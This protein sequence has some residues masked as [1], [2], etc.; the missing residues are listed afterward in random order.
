MT[1]IYEAVFECFESSF[2]YKSVPKRYISQL[3]QLFQQNSLQFSE[4]F[5]NIFLQLCLHFHKD[6]QSERGLKIIFSTISELKLKNSSENPEILRFLTDFLKLLITGC[7][8]RE[9][10]PRY[11]SVWLLDKILTLNIQELSLP[12]YIFH[13][14]SSITQDLLKDKHSSIRFHATNIAKKCELSTELTKALQQEPLKD[15]RKHIINIIDIDKKSYKAVIKRLKD[16]DPEVRL[17]ACKKIEKI[18][19]FGYCKEII[20]MSVVDRS[21]DVRQTAAVILKKYINDFGLEK[22]AET[23]EI[24]KNDIN[25]QKETIKGFKYVC[26]TIASESQ[27]SEFIIKNIDKV[28][29]LTIEQLLLLRISIE[30]LKNMNENLLFSLFSL[31]SLDLTYIH[32]VF[33]LFY[34]SNILKISLCLD[35]GEEFTRLSLMNTLKGLCISYPL[36]PSN[37]KESQKI[38]ESYSKLSNED[39]FPTTAQDVFFEI[40]SCMRFLLKDQENEFCRTIIETVNDIRDPLMQKEMDECTILNKKQKTLEK[41]EK[42]EDEEASLEEEI[43]SQEK[44]KNNQETLNR[45]SEISLKIS[46]VQEKLRILEENIQKILQRSLILSCELLR[47]S[48]HGTMDAELTEIV[49]TLIYPSLKLKDSHIHILAIEC[50]GLFCI[51]HPKACKDYLYIFKVIL[52]KK[53][54]SLLEFISLKSVF[55]FFMVYN[56]D[57]TEEN[58]ILDVISFYLDCSNNDIKNMVVEGLCKLLLLERISRTDLLAKLLLMFF[59]KTSTNPAKQALH[60]FFTHFVLVSERNA[61]SLAEGF[62]ITLALVSGNINKNYSGLSIANIN[63]NKM[64]SFVFMCLDPEFLKKNA[65]YKKTSNDHFLLFCYLSFE[66]IRFASFFQGKVYPRMLIQ[67][68]FLSFNSVEMTLAHKFLNKLLGIV[69]D[70]TCINAVGRVIENFCKN[71]ERCNKNCEELEKIVEDEYEKILKKAKLFL[72]GFDRVSLASK[73]KVEEDDPVEYSADDALGKRE[74]DLYEKPEKRIKIDN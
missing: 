56:F 51:N 24:K 8:T 62:F 13:K 74:D 12:S 46:K 33:P 6:P 47:L 39:F 55:D 67:V 3:Y 59:D 42:L 27:I 28:V 10:T 35:L 5:S 48:K 26:E 63:V 25:K 4:A 20:V 69:K 68:N 52:Q 70:K 40:V 44:F 22:I 2:E 16:F 50:L 32:P 65:E 14:I 38:F 64:F 53:G 21:K 49:Q 72:K 36:T 41:L 71:F 61:L 23:L 34:T 15:I 29:N 19:E 57:S 9:K 45:K 73:G 58:G 30:S 7:E 11:A 43:K 17:A 60:V 66:S 37:T 54:Q 31:S 18:E 1:E